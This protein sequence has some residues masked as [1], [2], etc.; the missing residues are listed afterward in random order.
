[1]SSESGLDSFKIRLNLGHFCNKHFCLAFIK[2]RQKMPNWLNLNQIMCFSLSLSCIINT[3]WNN[4][5]NKNCNIFF[6]ERYL[7][8]RHTESTDVYYT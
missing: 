3:Q 8:K 2:N 6:G 5:E 1:M 4:M 7:K